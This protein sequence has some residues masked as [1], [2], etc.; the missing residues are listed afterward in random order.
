MLGWLCFSFQAK[1]ANTIVIYVKANIEYKSRKCTRMEGLIHIAGII[2]INF[3]FLYSNFRCP[4]PFRAYKKLSAIDAWENTKRAA[5]D[6]ELKQ[7]EVR[8]S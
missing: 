7:I 4:L 8:N 1:F 6:A 5:V 2:L 3:S